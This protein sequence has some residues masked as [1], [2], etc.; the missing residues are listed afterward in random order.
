[1][2]YVVPL[3]LAFRADPLFAVL[4]QLWIA[5]TLQTY[6]TLGATS[7]S[8]GLLPLFPSLIPRAVVPVYEPPPSSPNT[9]A[10]RCAADISRPLIPIGLHFYASL[11]LP[12]LHHLWLH[13]GSA[14]ANFY[15][16]AGLV[17][18]LGNV[19]SGVE[20]VWVGRKRAFLRKEGLD[21]IA[22]W[23]AVQVTD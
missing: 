19:L 23:D 2:I 14:N 18:G 20:L 4:C 13:A 22:G 9:D 7:L 1:L 8:V 17:V 12:I 5:T 15:Y 16:A 10:G 11:L 21:G 3:C 6:P